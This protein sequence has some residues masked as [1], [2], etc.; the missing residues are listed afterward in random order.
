MDASVYGTYKLDTEFFCV[1]PRHTNETAPSN[2][3][4]EKI[5]RD[6]AH[7]LQQADARDY[8]DTL[9]SVVYNFDGVYSIEFHGRNTSGVRCVVIWLKNIRC[10]TSAP[11]S[12]ICS[13]MW[14]KYF[15]VAKC[16]A[17]LQFF[18]Y[19]KNFK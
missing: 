19:N 10:I 16:A 7:G 9:T 17:R 8:F 11:I 14:V 13:G 1:V 12:F 18:E 15:P 2:N 3:R 5:R 4:N 6:C